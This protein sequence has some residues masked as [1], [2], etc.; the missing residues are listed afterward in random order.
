MA[1]SS[2]PDQPHAQHLLQVHGALVAVDHRLP[3]GLQLPAQACLLVARGFEGRCIADD[4]LYL[5]AHAQ[6]APSFAA[7]GCRPF[8]FQAKGRTM[9]LSYWSAPAEA[10]DSPALMEPWA[11]LALQ[12][13]LAARRAPAVRRSRRS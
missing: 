4:Q 12:A 1:L 10:M 13:A 7:A 9:T 3:L 8:V 6:T 11:R 2:P 5:R